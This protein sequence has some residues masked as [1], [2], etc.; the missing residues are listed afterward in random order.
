MQCIFGRGGQATHALPIVPQPRRLRGRG[1]RTPPAQLLATPRESG[2]FPA[3]EPVSPEPEPILSPVAPQ[4]HFRRT[5]DPLDPGTESG[6]LVEVFGFVGELPQG[7]TGSTCP[8]GART[9]FLQ[10]S[11]EAR[12]SRRGCHRC[13]DDPFRCWRRPDSRLP[14][15]AGRVRGESSSESTAVCFAVG[16]PTV[17]CGY[18]SRPA[19]RPAKQPLDAV[20]P[21]FDRLAG[22]R[23]P[24]WGSCRPPGCSRRQ[25]PIEDGVTAV[26]VFQ[27]RVITDLGPAVLPLHGQFGQTAQHVEPEPALPPPA[28]GRS[29]W[30]KGWS[31]AGKPNQLIRGFFHRLL[32]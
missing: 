15:E 8:A 11:S 25:N 3:R 16:K 9:A 14:W 29:R 12:R 22:G 4:G 31:G 5:L 6:R 32:L 13:G 28:V 24:S 17:V 1:G 23:V 21:L 26:L 2:A 30:C 10:R 20:D 19:G 18:G 27:N 7:V